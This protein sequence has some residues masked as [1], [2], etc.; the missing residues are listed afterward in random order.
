MFDWFHENFDLVSDSLEVPQADYID[1]EAYY[2]DTAIEVEA[3]AGVDYID[4]ASEEDYF[5]IVV[6]GIDKVIDMK[7]EAEP[8]TK[9]LDKLG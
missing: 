9:V 8:G 6:E 7:I 1:S 2:I 3:E 5:D 4:I